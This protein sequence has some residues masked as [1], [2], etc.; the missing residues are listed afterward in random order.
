MTWYFVDSWYLIALANPLDGQH[1][2]ADRLRRTIRSGAL[3]THDGIFTEVLNFF[4]GSGRG[5]RERAALMIRRAALEFATVL[6]ADRLLF[7][8][9][10]TL[11]ESRSDKNYSLTDCMSMVVMEERGIS[12]VLTNDHHFSQ[13]G[14][15]VVN[16]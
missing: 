8:R 13:A 3:I 9:A 12:H 4:C 5:N 15:I 16:G 10:L 2:A 6:P 1:S 11:Y 14:F 7:S